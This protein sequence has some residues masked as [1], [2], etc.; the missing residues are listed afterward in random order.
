MPSA[1][2][3]SIMAL[4]D[5]HGL[6]WYSLHNPVNAHGSGRDS[7]TR[8]GD[9]PVVSLRALLSRPSY[10]C[11]A[12]VYLILTFSCERN[13]EIDATLSSSTTCDGGTQP[14][15]LSR[16]GLVWPS[17]YIGFVLIYSSLVNTGREEY[18][19]RR[20]RPQGSLLVHVWIQ[21]LCLF[22]WYFGRC[23]RDFSCMFLWI[24]LSCPGSYFYEHFS[25]K[26]DDFCAC[27]K[28]A[29][30]PDRAVTGPSGLPPV[31]PRSQP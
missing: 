29:P 14:S 11:W 8:V 22:T 16:W 9:L 5:F 28:F 25:L 12:A 7:T 31:A 10:W 19:L 1:I 6:G 17:L 26:I 30:G 2:F 15:V 23:R 27:L 3:L 20:I 13:Y 4:G 24:F 21:N 18:V